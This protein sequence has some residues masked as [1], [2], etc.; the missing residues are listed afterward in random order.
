MPETPDLDPPFSTTCPEC[1][2]KV[3]AWTDK[4]LEAVWEAHKATHKLETAAVGLTD[5][6]RAIQ[7]AAAMTDPIFKNEKDHEQDLARHYENVSQIERRL[8]Q[9]IDFGFKLANMVGNLCQEK[10]WRPKALKHGNIFWVPGGEVAF[11]LNYDPY[12]ISA[13]QEIEY[14]KKGYVR[15]PKLQ[16]DYPS[17]FEFLMTLGHHLT[18]MIEVQKVQPKDLS[19]TQLH[20]FVNPNNGI[21]HFAFK[22]VNRRHVLKASKAKL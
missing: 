7:A 12:D 13:P 3:S 6:E 19:F 11:E 1:L 9:L 18:N 14:L 17:V 20:H 22:I 21:D 2:L 15:L 5:A 16:A 10:D 4:A 8:P